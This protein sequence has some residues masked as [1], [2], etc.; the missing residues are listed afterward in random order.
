VLGGSFDPPHIGHLV[1]AQEV[2]WQLELD[3]V[4]LVPCLRSPHKP[5]GHRFDAE[6]RAQMVEAAVA[7]REGLLVSRVE[8]RRPPPSYTVDTLR[9]MAAEPGVRLWLI[10]GADQLRSLRAWHEPDAIL[11]LA[12]IA[13]V[14]RGEGAELPPEV[15][16]AR[17][18]RV[19]MPRIDISSTE[20]RR[21]IDDGRPFAH[22]LPP[23]VWE[24][25]GM[26]RA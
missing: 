12:R 4:R 25:M 22:L 21:R 7:G 9:Q 10:M 24:T 26:A 11:E 13:A 18:D 15:D 16:A 23:G 6:L 14:D 5:E 19:R 1:L 20:I 2:R 3:E 8:L 17:V